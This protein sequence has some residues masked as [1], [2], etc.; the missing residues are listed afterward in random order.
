MATILREWS[1]KYQWL[2]DT[3]SFMAALSVGGESKFRQLALRDLDLAA[4]AKVLDLCC[5]AGQA[6]QL[7]VQKFSQVTGLDASPFAIARAEQ[8]VPQANYVQGWA[9]EMPLATA[10]FDLVVTSTAMHEMTTSQLHQI[11]GEV[12][13]V[14]KVGGRFVIVDFHQP[15]NPLFV[16][17][18][19]MF[20]WLFETETA[21]ALLQTDLPQMAV[22]LGLNLE[23]QRLYAGGSLQVLQ[24][25]K[26]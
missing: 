6:T 25:V 16:L 17:P 24:F 10:E 15:T 7:L 2:Y 14:L 13:R 21:W 4:D 19:A 18:V 1:Y 8:R 3:I 23:I 11:F 22:G 26:V 12:S 9:E 5:G 20:L